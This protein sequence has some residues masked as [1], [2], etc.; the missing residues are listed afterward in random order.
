MLTD[1]KDIA[2]I[3][4]T[5]HS[6]ISEYV[7]IA[8]ATAILVTETNSSLDMDTQPGALFAADMYMTW[9]ENG[10]SNVDWWD[11]HNGVGTVSTVNGVT[12]Y[13]DRGS[14]PTR[15]S[16]GGTTEP[17]AETPFAPYYGIEML[18]KLVPGTRWSPP[19]QGT[20]WSGCTR[21]GARAAAWMC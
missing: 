21:S 2:G 10:V 12:D 8:A 20:P 11:E 7:G 15:P 3:I 17:A 1:P 5:L 9:L 19:L 6:A 14:S 4:T 13:G 16:G 18:T